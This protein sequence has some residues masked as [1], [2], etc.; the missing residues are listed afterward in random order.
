MEEFQDDIIQSINVFRNDGIILYPT[1]T[2]WGIGCQATNEAA[3]KKIYQLKKRDEKKS[4]IILVSDAAEIELYASKPSAKL[5]DILAN[6]KKPVT[7]IF[8]SAIN[9]PSLIINEDDTIAIRIV[10]DDFCNTLIRESGTP[11]V[12]TS[13]NISGEIYPPNFYDISEEIKSGVDYI[14]QHRRNDFNIYQP[15]SIIRLNSS[16]EIETI[17]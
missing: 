5:L 9:L 6:S 17:R 3:I 2:I 12:S 14:V 4:M 13:A 7:A 11:L 10:K 1:D 15:S 16:G 8:A